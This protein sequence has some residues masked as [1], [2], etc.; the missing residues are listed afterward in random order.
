MW[1]GPREA[2]PPHRF[3]GAAPGLLLAAW[4]GGGACALGVCVLS[5]RRCRAPQTPSPGGGGGGTGCGLCL[6]AREHPSLLALPQAS[7]VVEPQG[8]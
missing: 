2:A 7:A 1:S 3:P 8:L 5:S 4:G 6:S